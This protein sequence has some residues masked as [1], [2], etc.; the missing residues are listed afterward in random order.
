MTTQVWSS[1][2]HTFTFGGINIDQGAQGADDFITAEKVSPSFTLKV[3]AGGGT[4][5]CFDPSKAWLVKVKI[6]QTDPVN[7]KLMALHQLDLAESGG[8]GLVPAYIS[9]RLGTMKLV[10]TQAYIEVAPK[11]GVSKEESDYEW[12][13]MFP[14]AVAFAGGH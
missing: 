9:D 13:I 14:T 11:I 8:V 12:S 3:G 6:R 2:E 4:T 7:S 10:D 1:A 5:R